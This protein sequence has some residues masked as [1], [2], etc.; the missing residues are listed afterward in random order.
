VGCPQGVAAQAGD[1]GDQ[2]ASA[3]RCGEHGRVA[4]RDRRLR[5]QADCARAETEADVHA[6]RDPLVHRPHEPRAG[7]DRPEHPAGQRLVD[8]PEAAGGLAQLVEAER[9]QRPEL[10]VGHER[11]PP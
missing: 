1:G 6:A 9:G 10:G 7:P 3:R 11:M 5:R 8:R 2:R 4:P